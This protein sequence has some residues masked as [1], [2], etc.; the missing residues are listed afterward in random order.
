MKITSASS[1]G[2]LATSSSPSSYDCAVNN[3]SFACSLGG[4]VVRRFKPLEPFMKLL[5]P[6]YAKAVHV[7]E[8]TVSAMNNHDFDLVAYRA[9]QSDALQKAEK[10]MILIAFVAFVLLSTSALYFDIPK[11]IPAM[12]LGL[13]VVQILSMS[14]CAYTNKIAKH[15]LLENLSKFITIGASHKEIYNK[16]FQFKNYTTS[17]VIKL[18]ETLEEHQIPCVKLKEKLQQFLQTN[19]LL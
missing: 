1:G 8:R 13:V 4:F 10:D 2:L 17:G 9:L 12:V 5:F 7:H 6:C 15:Y 16:L 14:I 19:R 3:F 11:Y 18:I